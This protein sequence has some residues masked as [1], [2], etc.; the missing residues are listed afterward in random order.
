MT[1]AGGFIGAAATTGLASDGWS[2]RAGA[3]RALGHLAEHLPWTPCD[4]D[5][6]EQLAAA[7]GGAELVVHA[8]YGD[9]A[10]MPRQAENLLAAMSAA[11]V[12]NL[13]AF[14]SIA[15]YGERR[16]AIVE[17]DAPENALSPYAQAKIACE[18]L[19]RRWSEE[20]SER[21]VVA[22]RPG[23]VYGAGSKFWIEKLA[24]RIALGGWGVFGA[25]GR[26][27]AALIHIDDL[28]AQCGAACRIL[29][30]PERAR[31]ASFEALNC[32]GPETPNWNDYFQKLAEAL[33]E[34]PLR[35]WSRGEI[36]MR[37]ALALPAKILR[38]AGLPFGEAVS[39]APPPGELALFGRDARISGDKALEVLG[40]VPQITLA[41]GLRRSGLES[42]ARARQ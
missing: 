23:I 18:A 21:R 1:G 19:Y 40:F 34:K 3:R 42:F 16:G 7:V 4:L 24:R 9:D 15:V 14:S 27:R 11:G 39:L 6:P 32:V 12:V 38:R 13:L 29:A 25:C 8:A 37:Q 28:V 2:V 31:L 10:A 20:D 22:L 17:E 36:R 30:G 35:E 41:E 5:N 33:G 26:G